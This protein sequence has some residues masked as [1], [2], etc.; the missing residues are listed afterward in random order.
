MKQAVK[1]AFEN[2]MRHYE[3]M[4]TPAKAYLSNHECSVQEAVC[5]SLP[6]L[7]LKRIFMAMYVVN[8]NLPKE[9]VQVLLP[10]K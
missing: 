4:E 9:R 5:H 6:E 10:E 8:T 7:K 3:T 2:N 1:K